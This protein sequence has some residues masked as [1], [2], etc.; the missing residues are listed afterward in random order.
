MSN[1]SW[2]KLQRRWRA[3]L[4]VASFLG[5]AGPVGAQET[6]RVIGQ[7]TGQSGAPVAGAQVYIAATN[8]GT[9]TNAEGRYL[10]PNVPVGTHEMRA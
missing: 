9:L 5:A 2:P 3:G 7:V 10:I 4:L 8:Q 6:G 1:A